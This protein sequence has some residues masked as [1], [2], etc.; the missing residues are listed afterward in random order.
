MQETQNRRKHT[1]NK[2][3]TIKKMVTRSH[4]SIIILNVHGLNA[5]TK[6]HRLAAWIQ[7][8]DLYSC[9]LQETHLRSRDTYRLKVRGWKKVF[10][11]N[12]NQK[13]ARVAIL[14][15][16]KTD[17]KTKTIIGDKEGDYIMI[18]GSIQEDDITII[19]IYALNIGAPQHVRQILTTIK[20]ENDCSTIIV[21]DF[22]TLLSSIDHS[23][24]KSIRKYWP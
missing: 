14:I 15:S 9:S 3:K 5:P 13:K 21:G 4:I 1:K 7:K 8:Q 6:R 18:M 16:D 12:R 17:F 22:N 20:G 2:P 19:S 10:H 23:H 24:R 11:A